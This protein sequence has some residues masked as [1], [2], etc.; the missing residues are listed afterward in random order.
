[1]TWADASAGFLQALPWFPGIIASFRS[2]GGSGGLFVTLLL[3]VLVSSCCCCVGCFLGLV[4]AGLLGPRWPRFCRQ[5]CRLWWADV[6]EPAR[7]APANARLQGYLR[8]G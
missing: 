1:M 6:G 4:L 3:L 8:D 2:G 5:L 7:Q